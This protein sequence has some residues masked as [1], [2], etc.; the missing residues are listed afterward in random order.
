[1]KNQKRKF[2]E[3]TYQPLKKQ[4]DTY[5]LEDDFDSFTGKSIVKFAFRNKEQ[6]VSSWT[7]MYIEVLRILYNEDKNILM[8]LAVSDENSGLPLYFSLNNDASCYNKTLGNEIHICT[9][10]A[11][12]GKLSVLSKLFNLYE[13]EC[14][15]LVFYLEEVN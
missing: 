11:T 3:T 15:D 2:P 14:N 9:N 1:M 8:R 4:F 10:T 5:S 13:L 6:N 12:F 7:E